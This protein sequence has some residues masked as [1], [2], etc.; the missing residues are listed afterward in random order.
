MERKEIIQTLNNIIRDAQEVKDYFAT[1]NL[2]DDFKFN[3]NLCKLR[4][5]SRH[6]HFLWLEVK[7]QAV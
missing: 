1:G 5:T 7:K 4:D 2:K 3:L 6:Y